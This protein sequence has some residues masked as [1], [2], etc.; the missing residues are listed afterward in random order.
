VNIASAE[1]AFNIVNIVLLGALAFVS[2]Y[3]FDYTNSMSVS[4]AAES[5]RDGLHRFPRQFSFGASQMVLGNP[6]IRHGYLNTLFRTVVGTALT[7]VVT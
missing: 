7:L 6:D 2:L 3:L 5:N 1:R 4:T